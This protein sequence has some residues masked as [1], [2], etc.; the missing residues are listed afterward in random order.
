MH[1]RAYLSL[2]MLI[3]VGCN[4]VLAEPTPTPSATATASITPSATHTVTA[5]ATVTNTP[6]ATTTPTVTHTPTV[7]NTPTFTPT[8][9]VTPVAMA[10]FRPDS[11]A[12]LDT[13]PNNL[14]T[15]SNTSFILFTNSNNQ[16]TVRNA[17]TAQPENTTEVLY[18][19]RAGSRNR[20]ALA[21]FNASLSGNVWAAENGK[22]L[23]YFV[24]RGTEVGV[25]IMNI[26]AS[27]PFS[28]R[29]W[30]TNT[31]AQRGFVSEP[32]W[33]ADGE[34]LALT[35]ATPY[36]LDIY[37]YSRDGSRRENLTEHGSYDMYPAFSPDGRYMAFVSDRATC[38][39][40]IPGEDGFCDYLT[41][42]PPTGGTVH[43]MDLATREVEQLSDVFV[44]EPPRWINNRQ[45][46]FAGG[47]Q[48][49]LLNPQRT[50]WLVNIN[51]RNIQ[52]VKATGDSDNVLYL[53][54][55]WSNDGFQ[56]VVQRVTS[57]DSEIVM[58]RSDGTIVRRRSALDFPRFGMSADWSR[59]GDRVAIGGMDGTCP[60]G[61]RVASGDFEWVATGN[62]PPSMCSPVYSPDG[63]DIA[64][65]GVN[66]NVDGRLDVYSSNANG[67]GAANLTV[68]LNGTM[69]LIGWIGGAP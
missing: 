57:S 24:P 36:D 6:T 4:A 53:S 48:N 45:L 59:L 39:S 27:T 40:W 55:A 9:S 69:T 67:F 64:F 61:I 1:K 22:A 37:L 11:L 43:L 17:A 46:V 35:L 68:D 44:T 28:T 10:P 34:Q 31:L 52:Q 25:H 58:M 49:D 23:A 62:V 42:D 33:T 3:L 41:D 26:R 2:L 38:P 13:I 16:V 12:L 60:Y 20:I 50:L 8:A 7:T 15:G 18:L 5:T 21:E 14:R 30:R 19:T 29:I 56:L 66:P 65:T 51:T 32:T 54:D 47:D 63:S